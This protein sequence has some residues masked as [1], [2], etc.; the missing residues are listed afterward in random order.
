V[1]Q[2]TGEPEG[3]EGQAIRWATPSEVADLTC[4][5]ST[6]AALAALAAAK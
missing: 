3:A 6:H 1:P 4:T 2:W 5:P